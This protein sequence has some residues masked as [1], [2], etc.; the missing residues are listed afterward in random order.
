MELTQRIMKAIDTAPVVDCHE[1]IPPERERL[2]R[3]WDIFS[4]LF[5]AYIDAD[6]LSAGA[7]Q[8]TVDRVIQGD[9]SVS[10]KWRIIK[11]P[12]SRARRTGYGRTIE[13]A[14]DR[15]FGEKD[16]ARGGAERADERL[17]EWNTPGVYTRVLRDACGIRTSINQR[18]D[19][20]EPGEEH[21]FTL[22][23]KTVGRGAIDR[24][25]V[26]AEE[27]RAGK[28]L[29]TLD[30]FLAHIRS[31]VKTAHANGAVALKTAAWHLGQPDPGA[32]EIA[33][34]LFG[35]DEHPPQKGPPLTQA[36]AAYT[37]V[38]R[39][40]PGYAT[41]EDHRLLC[42]VYMHYLAEL[43]GELGMTVAVHCGPGWRSWIDYRLFRVEHIMP[44]LRAHPDTRFD[45]YHAGLP[46]P[47]ELAMTLKL[48]PNAW[49]DLT[50]AHIIAPEM[51]VS[52]L[53]ELLDMLPSNKVIGFGGD[54]HF[55][56]EI[57]YGHLVIAR[58]NIARALARRVER[59]RL[60]EE[61]AV[62]MARAFLYDNPVQAY[63]LNNVGA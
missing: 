51:T 52:F 4:L 9:E 20:L 41:L 28:R 61:D 25:E 34:Y 22:S 29:S 48:C 36:E 60:N 14:L 45:I 18:I 54:V 42:N 62:D 50:W 10:E 59:G 21:L 27:A 5:L 15:F 43:A 12:W 1:H 16:F 46:W 53:D 58:E 3:E 39:A 56:P 47:R 32:P 63:Q 13:I 26:E 30:D 7:S 2:A 49:V 24:R 40:A 33:S 44:L 23:I 6:L 37:R 19:G 35:L 57:A 17:R 55:A 11:A 38:M 8:A 31:V